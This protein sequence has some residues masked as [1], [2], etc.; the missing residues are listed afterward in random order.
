[1]KEA[2]EVA[3]M[4]KYNQLLTYKPYPKQMEF[5]DAGKT[6]KQRCLMAANKIGKTHSAGFEV[7]MHATGKYPDWWH[8]RRFT[9][10]PHIWCAGKSAQTTRDTVQTVLLGKIRQDWGTGAIPRECI[11]G[12]PTMAR[13]QP[14]CVD[15]IKVRHISGDTS[16]I[17][18]KSYEQSVSKWMGPNIDLVWYDEE[19]EDPM[20]YDEG[21]MRTAQVDGITMMTFTPLLGVTEIVNRFWP[22]LNDAS[23]HHL[24]QM[25]MDDAPHFADNPK[26]YANA[27]A[28]MPD[29]QLE[30][31]S[32][33]IPMLGHGAVFPF[34]ESAIT[35]EPFQ[36]PGYW[37]IIGGVDFGWDHPTA[38]AWCAYDK[39][40]DT[41]Y[42]TNE[43]R[44][45]KQ[46]PVVHAAALRGPNPMM[47]WAWPSDG[48]QTD[49]ASGIPLAHTYRELGVKML[50]EHA[51]NEVPGKAKGGIGVE[52]GVLKM[53]SMMQ[54]GRFKVFTSCPMWFQEYRQYHRKD[55]MIVKKNDDL[56]CASRYALMMLK[57]ARPR[58]NK[59][60]VGI[61]HGTYDPISRTVIH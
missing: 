31:R 60:H 46:T 18:F 2:L 59:E 61:V 4:A 55:G 40:N 51:R 47:S 28:G 37:P 42:V 44:M 3:E 15:T 50:G 27:L 33:G 16:L 25:T 11:I 48:L 10:A 22:E 19:P 56:L 54:T 43:Y 49:K 35:C 21:V 52:A 32:K 17:Q 29:Y 38:A 6:S 1:M 14:D 39:A 12:D 26:L 5:H 41:F 13:G 53:F 7:A 9:K 58:V 30:A 36:I 45:A 23:V 57:W 24:T 8:G 34:P 20:L